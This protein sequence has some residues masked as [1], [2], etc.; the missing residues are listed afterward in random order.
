VSYTTVD[1]SARAGDG[2][3]HT[4]GEIHFAEQQTRAEI[5]VTL[6]AGTKRHL[7]DSTFELVLTA[8]Q[9]DAAVL[10]RKHACA[11]TVLNDEE[12]LPERLR[13]DWSR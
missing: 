9:P 5:T 4:S 7:P 3:V 10:G 8:A 6:D 12:G 13:V 2:Y 11:V 1:A